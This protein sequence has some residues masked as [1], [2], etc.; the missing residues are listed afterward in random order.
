M[1]LYCSFSLGTSKPH[2]GR[3][4]DFP[5]HPVVH[6]DWNTVVPLYSCRKDD[7]SCHYI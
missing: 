4:D 5:D 3:K 6:R 2:G 1:S 7:F